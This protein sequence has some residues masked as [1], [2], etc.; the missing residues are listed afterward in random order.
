MLLDIEPKQFANLVKLGF[1][2][3][4]IY[5]A[6]RMRFIKEYAGQ[7]FSEY[8]GLTGESPINLLFSTVR[9]YVPNLVMNAPINKVTTEILEMKDYA[10]MM[11]EALN[12]LH[13]QIQ[14]KK[15]LRGWVTDSIFGLGIL[16]T[17][18][19][20]SDNIISV[21]GDVDI[22]PG[23]IFTQLVDIDNCTL[24]PQ[25]TS[26]DKTNFFGHLVRVRRKT[27]LEIPGL[28][29]DLIMGLSK[30]DSINKGQRVEDIS[31]QNT[32]LYDIEDYVEVVK[33]WVPDANA[34]VYIPD[35]R[36]STNDNFIGIKDFY[37]PK[38]GPYNFLS[39]TPPIPNNPLPVSSASIW[40]DLHNMVN[41]VAKKLM[42]QTDKQRD[43]FFYRP[44][45]ADLAQDLVES[46][47]QDW[48]ASD[49]PNAVNKQSLSGPNRDNVDMLNQ[50][51]YWYNYIAGNP[52]Q[53]AGTRLNAETA[54]GQQIL[55]NNANVTIEDA[56]DIIEEETAAI[57]EKHAWYIDTDPLI[58]MPII[59]RETGGKEIQLWLTPEQR[60]GNIT[61]LTCTIK[62][63]SMQ[64]LDPQIRTKR[65]FE[66]TTNVVTA[67]VNAAQMC[68][69]AGIPFN[70]QKYLTNAA[71]ELGIGDFM[72]EVF[73]D[74]EFQKRISIMMQLNPGKASNN[75]GIMQ[76]GGLPTMRS[77]LT[78]QQEQNKFSQQIAGEAQSNNQGVY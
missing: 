62:H 7:Y 54:T 40:Y 24:D 9:A 52:D 37:G 76:N 17:G 34:V 39:F 66:F 28:S 1:D 10:F 47:D 49:D 23:M 58:N 25:C 33:V 71:E 44:M 46:E 67:A 8:K 74:P 18:L 30:C 78:E 22:D 20:A 6:S 41:R 48:L 42:K 5:R 14:L 43:V 38:T 50:L 15:I 57:S 53:I 4:K 16:E 19:C 2:R 21:E 51:Q 12:R 61:D 3:L 70:L 36:I 26:L 64:R 77:I 69:Q 72:T 31:K 55:Q 63:R 73:D 59:K 35:P 13:K 65:I 68:T 11:S 56:R 45:Y 27:L 60:R 29:E 32:E 75:S